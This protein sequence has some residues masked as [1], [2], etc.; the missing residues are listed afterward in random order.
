MITK[1]A[2]QQVFDD[3]DHQGD[4]N[5]NG[6]L[7]YGYFFTDTD[8]AKLVAACEE[9]QKMGYKYVDIFEPEVDDGDEPFY[10]LHVEK[11]ETH[12]VDSLDQR[13]KELYKFADKFNLDS[14]DGFD[15]GHVDFD[16]AK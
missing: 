2:I 8:G 4:M 3:L 5:T 11:V 15:V 12:S 16:P 1:D 6:P 7:L 9:L 13:N 14:Y 10:Y